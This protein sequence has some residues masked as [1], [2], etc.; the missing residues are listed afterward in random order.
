[1]ALE[2]SL[3]EPLPLPKSSTIEDQLSKINNHLRASVS[4]WQIFWYPH[5][6]KMRAAAILGL[7][8]SVH[9]LRPFQKNCAAEWVIGL[10]SDP[11]GLD[12]MLIFGGDG[13]LHRHLGSLPKLAIPVLVVPTGSGNDF[14]R[15]LGIA[16]GRD[17]LQA[18]RTFTTNARNIR[19][20]DL[21]VI[22][23][24]GTQKS[25]QTAAEYPR[26]S[27]ETPRYFS[28]AAGVGIDGEISRYANALPRW[29]RAH[30]GYA[31]SLAP[32]LV[33]FKAFGMKLSVARESS[34]S[35]LSPYERKGLAAVFANTPFYG[36]GMRIAPRAKMDDGLLDACLI[37]NMSKVKLI[38]LFPT[39]YAGR[40]IGIREVEYFTVDR[41]RIETEGPMN[42]YADGEYVCPTPVE[43]GVARSALK[44]I[45]PPA[46]E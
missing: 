46:Q 45:V 8:S 9:D 19:T 5:P 10:P 38:S 18:W 15:S 3:H 40:H 16:S 11:E 12:A 44:V 32:A 20:V 42:V 31:L 25:D 13:T 23:P 26:G 27:I 24:L 41:A 14:A 1:M 6:S 37:A 33:T 7:G 35:S 36:G 43:F 21:G 28:C 2:S 34:G 39:V 22:I 17:A 30:G 29:L 4:R